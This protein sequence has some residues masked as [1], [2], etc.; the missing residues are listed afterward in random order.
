M[1]TDRM[2]DVRVLERNLNK[3][4]ISREEFDKYV[5]DLADAE[6]NSTTISAEFVEGVLLE[7]DEE[8]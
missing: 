7:R 1:T 3:G 4:L 8:E 6:A 5:A 2:F